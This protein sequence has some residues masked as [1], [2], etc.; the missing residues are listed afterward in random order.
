MFC[1]ECLV[2]ER[3]R[4]VFLRIHALISRLTTSYTLISINKAAQRTKSL[5]PTPGPG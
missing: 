5:A 3:R 2:F 4:Q 1:T